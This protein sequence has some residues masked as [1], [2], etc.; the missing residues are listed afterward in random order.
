M[1]VYIMLWRKVTFMVI[2]MTAFIVLWGK[3]ILM[4]ILFECSDWSNI[5]GK[6]KLFYSH[7]TGGKF[8]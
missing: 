3:V 4:V 6:F 2:V 5:G 8:E 7:S 1:A